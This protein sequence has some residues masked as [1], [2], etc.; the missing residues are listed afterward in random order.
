M[1]ARDSAPTNPARV[2]RRRVILGIAAALGAG[3][4]ADAAC[5]AEPPVL[6]PSPAT[7]AVVA[8]LEPLPTA[9]P[10]VAPEPTPTAAGRIEERTFFSPILGR[11]MT[12]Q[13]YLPAG[14]GT[15]PSLRYA[16]VYMLHGVAG[17]STEWIS[18]GIDKAADELLASGDIHPFL[19]VFPN[20][21]TSYYIDHP[22][23]GA[24]WSQYMIR[25]VVGAVDRQNRTIAAAEARAVGGLSMGGDGA[26]QLGFRFPEVFGVIGSHSPSSR[27]M[28]EH[29][30]ADIYDSDQYFRTVSPYWIAQRATRLEQS[31]I[32]IDIGADD[33]WEWNARALHATL[34]ARSVVHQYNVLDGK[35][36]AEYWIEHV[37]KYL[38]FY[39]AS[40]PRAR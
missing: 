7:P 6:P 38:R 37:P 5:S 12:Y 4:F 10:T 11:D 25:D 1:A 13:V 40:L 16:A 28:F 14:Y 30:P 33:H 20:G 32:W 17:D 23:Y 21:G 31:K 18:I 3:V 34:E 39:A 8:T 36:E 22:R 19:I 26:L 35:H 27:L 2:V 9:R 15:S 24:N 29:V